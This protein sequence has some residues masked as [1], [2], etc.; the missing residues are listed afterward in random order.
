MGISAGV[1]LFG[2]AMSTI[3]GI[4]AQREQ[5]KAQRMAAEALESAK[6]SL[7]V[8]YME[9]VQIPIDAFREQSL[10]TQA[11]QAQALES[12]SEAGQRAAI[13][14]VGRVQAQVTEMD[15]QARLDMQNALYRREM[16]LAGEESR[17]AQNLASLS[18]QEAEGAQLAARDQ[19]MMA[20]GAFTSAAEGIGRAG[21]AM[22]EGSKLYGG[23]QAGVRRWD[24]TTQ[25]WIEDMAGDT[26]P[27]DPFMRS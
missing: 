6:K 4:K 15:R 1:S 2:T 14:G 10:A 25:S 18:L 19:Q 7:S 22:Y 27:V 17:I 5:K 12:L 11:R 24:P 9:G 13:G 3:Q 23:R 21:L 26:A 16:M 8:N 20:A